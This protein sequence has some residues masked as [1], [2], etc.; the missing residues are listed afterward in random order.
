MPAKLFLG[1]APSNAP[2]AC[3]EAL[4]PLFHSWYALPYRPGEDWF[5]NDCLRR[6]IER[7]DIT[8]ETA[9]PWAGQDEDWFE[10]ASAL[11]RLV[12]C[13]EVYNELA[14]FKKDT[15]A[16]VDGGAPNTADA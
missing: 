8:L 12:K 11:L 9:E 6:D 1:F 14:M 4:E 15:A 2:S 16:L 10:E 3:I 5:G 13:S 7:F